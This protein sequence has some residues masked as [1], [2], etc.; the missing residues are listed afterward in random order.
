MDGPKYQLVQHH[1]VMVIRLCDAIATVPHPAMEE[2]TARDQKQRRK[3]VMEEIVQYPHQ[4][5]L[6][7]HHQVHLYQVRLQHLIQVRRTILVIFLL[8]LIPP[9][10]LFLLPLI[11]THVIFCAPYSPYYIGANK[12]SIL[13]L[14]YT[15]C[16]TRIESIATKIDESAAKAHE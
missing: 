12:I 2:V 15:S 3:N 6:H 1:V 7:Q 8:P 9:L 13:G 5:C 10:S 14:I 11:P 16:F 4:L